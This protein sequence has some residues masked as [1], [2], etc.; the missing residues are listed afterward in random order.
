MKKTQGRAPSDTALFIKRVRELLDYDP[1]MGEFTR[2]GTRQGCKQGKTGSVSKTTGYLRICIDYKEYLAH[3]LAWLLCCGEW[4]K[5][6]IDHINQD[7]LD[8]RISNLRDVGFTENG[9]NKGIQT[10]N[11]TGVTGVYRARDKYQTV[12]RVNGVIH[13]LG[14]YKTLDEARKVRKKAE[15]KF[16]FSPRH[17]TTESFNAKAGA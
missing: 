1:E 8:N 9:R 17:G 10:N 11:S 16:G 2:T 6:Q 7:R 12:I 15:R 5:G 4:P 14:A 13:Y 3:R